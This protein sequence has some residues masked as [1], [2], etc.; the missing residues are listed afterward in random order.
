MILQYLSLVL[1]TLLG[2]VAAMLIKKLSESSGIKNLITN[3]YLY[4]GCLLYFSSTLINW[5]VLEY[6]EYSIVLPSTALNYVWTLFLAKSFLDE[7]ITRRKSLGITMILLGV[8]AV[9]L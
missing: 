9:T 8:I 7:K 4:L 3:K 6:L 5:W 1:M 2:A